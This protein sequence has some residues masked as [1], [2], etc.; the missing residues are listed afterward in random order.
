MGVKESR[1]SFE[2]NTG[3]IFGGESLYSV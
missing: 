2:R 3:D 1:I